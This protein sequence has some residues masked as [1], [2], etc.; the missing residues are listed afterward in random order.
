MNDRETLFHQIL[1][2]I[3]PDLG[4]EG[5]MFGAKCIKAPNGK[6]AAFFWKDCMVFKLNEKDRSEALGIS[7]AT[8]GSHLYDPSKPM[9][10]WVSV[11]SSQSEHWMVLSKKALRYV[12]QIE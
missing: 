12:G 8:I 6:T 4:A 1:T 5:K 10:G 2:Q 11:P 7:G 3:P 9:K